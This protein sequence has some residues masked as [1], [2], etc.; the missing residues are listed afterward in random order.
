[1]NT[2]HST[3]WS[4]F[5]RTLGAFCALAAASVMFAQPTDQPANPTGSEITGRDITGSL[6]RSGA[7]NLRQIAAANKLKPL[8]TTGPELNWT[9]PRLRP[10]RRP[11]PNP[12][13]S[14][15]VPTNVFMPPSPNIT[16][17]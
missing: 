15:A 17:F 4:F 8:N 1:M 13:L 7:V 2:L 9:K 16:T 5:R 14:P 3:H 11:N 6:V 12:Q 10:P